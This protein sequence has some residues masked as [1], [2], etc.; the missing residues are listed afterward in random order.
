MAVSNVWTGT[1]LNNIGP[2]L[3][4]KRNVLPL[5]YSVTS[6]LNKAFV[7]AAPLSNLPKIPPSANVPETSK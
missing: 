5:L 7:F 4:L 6:D 3:R 1:A 2:V